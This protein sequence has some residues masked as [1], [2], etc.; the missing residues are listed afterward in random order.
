MKYFN[1]KEKKKNFVL[2]LF[3]LLV[4]FNKKKDY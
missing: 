1:S 2:K 4:Y 3:Y